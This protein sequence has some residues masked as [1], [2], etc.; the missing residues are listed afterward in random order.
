MWTIS[1]KSLQHKV[2]LKLNRSD[3]NIPDFTA[4]LNLAAGQNFVQI[5]TNS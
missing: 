4:Y 1:Y 5:N 3:T 2:V